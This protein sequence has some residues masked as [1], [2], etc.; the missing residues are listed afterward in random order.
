MSLRI[1][2]HIAILRSCYSNGNDRLH[3]C[4]TWIIQLYSLDGANVHPTNTRTMVWFAEPTRVHTPSSI[5][6][7]S[8]VL[9]GLRF[10]PERHG[11]SQRCAVCAVHCRRHFH[12]EI[13]MCIALHY[14]ATCGAAR[15][16]DAPCRVVPDTL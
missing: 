5:S 12:T 14:T 2:A 10:F 13:S 4:R 6:I 15:R 7:G 9:Y 11:A 1:L 3:S 8:E 16:R